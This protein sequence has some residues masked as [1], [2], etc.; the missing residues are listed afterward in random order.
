MASFAFRDTPASE[1]PAYPLAGRDGVGLELLRNL[2]QRHHRPEALAS[3]LWQEHGGRAHL[4]EIECSL[5]DAIEHRRDV[6][7]R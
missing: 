7:L 3:G 6:Q 2:A 5:P 4:E 1:I